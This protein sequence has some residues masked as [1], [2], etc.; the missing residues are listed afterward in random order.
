MKI[1]EKIIPEIQ[2]AF[3]TYNGSYEKI[4]ELLGAVIGWLMARNLQ[5]KMP[6]Y[7]TYY[8]SPMEVSPDELEYE[9]GAAFLGNAE[10]EGEI[11]VK[12]IPE[13][14]VLASVFKGHYGKACSIYGVIFEYATKNGYQIS[15]SVTE[16]YLNSP[17]NVKEEDLLTEV[18]F[19]V[20]KE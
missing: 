19:P 5:I 18:I 3:T 7:G 15:G 20:V 16:S 4:P 13:H 6:I 9:V 12:K 2:V 17:N 10:T 8:N 14:K 1:E 11:K